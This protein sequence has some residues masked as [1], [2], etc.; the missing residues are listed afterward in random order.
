MKQGRLLLRSINNGKSKYTIFNNLMLLYFSFRLPSIDDKKK[1]RFP[2]LNDKTKDKVEGW[3]K[4]IRN[5]NG[6]I[7]KQV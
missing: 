6:D 1:N 2:D 5:L 4:N 7:G 3:C